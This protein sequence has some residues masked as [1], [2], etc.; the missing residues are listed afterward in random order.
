MNW[1]DRHKLEHELKN[2][3]VITNPKHYKQNAGENENKRSAWNIWPNK[4][5]SH[6]F[7][8]AV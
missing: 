7:D 5:A 2:K 3:K 1:A 4:M 6:E 8:E